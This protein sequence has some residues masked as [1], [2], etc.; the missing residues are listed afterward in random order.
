[1]TAKLTKELAAALHAAGGREL[2]VV[3]P[4]TQRLY[5]VVDA[6]VHR[7]AMEALR[8]QQD[9]D[10]IAQGISEMEAGEGISL[11]EAFDD[12]RANLGIRQRQP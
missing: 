5:F 6:E 4:D 11:D 2:E 8:R 9:R 12:I 3:D 10:A 7:Q 1:M